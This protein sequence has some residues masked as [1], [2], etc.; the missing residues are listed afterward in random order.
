MKFSFLKDPGM[1]LPTWINKVCSSTSNFFY[2]LQSKT[3]NV[4]TNADIFL[5][6]SNIQ[7]A[8]VC[9]DCQFLIAPAGLFSSQH[10]TIDFVYFDTE[11]KLI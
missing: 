2:V 3:W 10:V 5:D 4:K 1:V 6:L 9:V 8:C 11:R 7:L